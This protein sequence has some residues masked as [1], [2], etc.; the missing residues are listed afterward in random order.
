MHPSE[1]RAG[2]LM[3]PFDGLFNYFPTLSLDVGEGAGR[4]R[5]LLIAE[6][7]VLAEALSDAELSVQHEGCNEARRGVSGI[8]EN[9]GQGQGIVLQLKGAI[10]TYLVAVGVLP[11]EDRGMCGQG[12]R[13]GAQHLLEAHSLRGQSVQ[14]GRLG[15]FVAV[16][17]EAI[18]AQRVQGNQQQVGA[19][20]QGFR[21]NRR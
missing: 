15:S 4:F 12:G 3:Q 9:L 10:V 19:R 1:E 20:P 11:R 17:A 18:S 14:M 6:V 21:L 8:I 7:G 13:H 16:R 5:N 2:P